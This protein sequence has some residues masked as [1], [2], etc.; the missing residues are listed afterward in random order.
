MR[1]LLTI[2]L[3]LIIFRVSAQDYLHVC[4][5]KDKNFGVPF[6]NGSIYNWQIQGDN[7]IAIITS[8]NGT[9]DIKID[10]NSFGVFQLFVEEITKTTKPR[11]EKQH[12][13]NPW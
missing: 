12:Q 6:S 4:V 1:F 9:N 3:I 11:L 10:L 8:G 5:G 7:N 2:L 13:R